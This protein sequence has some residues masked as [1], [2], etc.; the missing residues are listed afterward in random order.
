MGRI[1]ILLAFFAVAIQAAGD[2]ALD[3]ATLR[4]LKS[5]SV[6]IDKID[7]E[8][9]QQG[10]T[11]DVLQR[12][13]EQRLKGAGLTIDPAAVEFVGL[14]LIATPPTR[15]QPYAVS[16]TLGLYQRVTLSRDNNIKT[17][18]QTWET[19]TVLLAPPKILV[20]SSND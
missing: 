5:V 13:L 8:L 10:L 7:P 6:V 2:A 4:G 3:R 12:R 1:L 20:S 15:R 17:A 9:E 18:T 11:M 16:L 14:R 19:G